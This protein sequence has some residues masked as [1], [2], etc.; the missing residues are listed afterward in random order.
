MLFSRRF[1]VENVLYEVSF[2]RGS[3]SLQI[4]H[5]AL[6]GMF[7]LFLGQYFLIASWICWIRYK[8]FSEHC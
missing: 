4:Y 5:L 7:L 1:H 3:L 8:M 2:S 6:H